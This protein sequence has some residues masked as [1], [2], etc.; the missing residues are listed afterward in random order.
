[1]A[2]GTTLLASQVKRWKGKIEADSL[3]SRGVAIELYN[4]ARFYDTM[5]LAQ[6]PM[7]LPD[8]L[9]SAPFSKV[10]ENP[11]AFVLKPYFWRSW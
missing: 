2:K 11:E 8:D 4:A 9:T 1:M 10:L 7:Y 3:K 6:R 5:K